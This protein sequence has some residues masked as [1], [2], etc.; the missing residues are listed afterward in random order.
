M[1]TAQPTT[2]SSF[3]FFEFTDHPPDVLQS[4]LSFFHKGSPTNPLVAGEWRQAL[5]G[6]QSRLIGYEC[7]AY[8]WGH[9]MDRAAGERYFHNRLSP[10]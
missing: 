6:C 5:P 4:R 2:G 8:I 1:N 9:C 7:P 10:G 3:A